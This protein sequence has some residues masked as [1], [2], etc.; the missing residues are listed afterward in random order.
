MTKCL[1]F[2]EIA[3]LQLHKK[4]VLLLTEDA[5]LDADAI[6]KGNFPWLDSTVPVGEDH[7]VA[8]VRCKVERW[9][10]DDRSNKEEV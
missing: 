9:L 1:H 2:A 5:D 10:I 8:S 4:E 6:M 7:T 3:A